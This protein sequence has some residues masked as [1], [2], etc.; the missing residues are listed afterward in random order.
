MRF[1]IDASVAVKWF[2]RETTGNEK[3][4]HLLYLYREDR[5]SLVEPELF[6][7]ERRRNSPS[8]SKRRA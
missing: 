2:V 8:F 3:A 4:N 6:L 1:V 5:I 7:I